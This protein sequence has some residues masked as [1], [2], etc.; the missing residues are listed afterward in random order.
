MA[1]ETKHFE[2]KEYQHNGISVYVQID[3]DE[4]EISLCNHDGSPKKW[5]FAGRSIAYMEAWQNIL[6]A[7]SYAVEEARKELKK[8]LDVQDKARA[9]MMIAVSKVK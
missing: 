7:M 4:G 8:H 3:Y 5:V 9:K 6:N 2:R 1:T